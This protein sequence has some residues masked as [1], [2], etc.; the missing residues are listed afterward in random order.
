MFNSL[1]IYDY[2]KG[3]TL[4]ESTRDDF[5]RK[6]TEIVVGFLKAIDAWASEYSG[7]GADVFQT[8]TMR[9]TFKKSAEFNLTFAYCT[10]ISEPVEIDKERL[11]TIKYAFI[12]NFWETF[13]SEKRKHF[14]QEE[15]E[16]FDALLDSL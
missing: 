12:H 13:T 7:K 5:S 10:D 4:F 6:N 1:I 3:K 8:K 9:I 14:T 15:R 11:E 16:R 2:T